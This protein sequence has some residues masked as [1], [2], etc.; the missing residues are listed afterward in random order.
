VAGAGGIF[1][2]VPR[3]GGGLIV[4]C[5]AAGYATR[6]HKNARNRQTA[7]S[8]EAKVTSITTRITLPRK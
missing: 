5:G 1:D 7:T 3:T 2:V 4:G 6:W 8:V